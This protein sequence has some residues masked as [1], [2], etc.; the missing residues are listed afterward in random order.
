MGHGWLG[1]CGVGGGTGD[2]WAG[3]CNPTLDDGTVMDGAPGFVEGS[4]AI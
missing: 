2:L 4:S 1:S 3:L